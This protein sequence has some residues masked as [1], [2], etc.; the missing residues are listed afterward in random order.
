M[1]RVGS[2]LCQPECFSRITR[3]RH[4]IAFGLKHV[5][6]E[7][8]DFRVIINDEYGFFRWRL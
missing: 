1:D 4:H 7:S 3:P 6:N 5:C 8:Q 2:S